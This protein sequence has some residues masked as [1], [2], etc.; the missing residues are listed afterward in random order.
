LKDNSG[1]IKIKWGLKM[2]TKNAFTERRKDRRFKLKNPG[3]AIMYYSPTKIGHIIDISESG[4]AVSYVKTGQPSE[5]LNEIDIFRSDF[6]CYI[7]NLKAKTI[8]DLKI[9]D[10]T[11][12]GSKE[13][14]RCGIHFK[15]L[16]SQ[17]ISQLNNFIQNY[18]SSEEN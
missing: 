18:A 13:T 14:R 3:Y 16:S 12:M 2:D 1:Q 17:Q 10:P 15:D 11:Y 4:L 7:E 5:K 6:R 8:S 9:N